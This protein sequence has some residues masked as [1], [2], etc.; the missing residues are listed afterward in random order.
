MSTTEEYITCPECEGEGRVWFLDWLYYD[1]SHDEHE[2]ECPI[3][4][5]SGEV[6]SDE[7][8][9]EEDID[10]RWEEHEERER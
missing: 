9:E 2:E 5:G 1:G 10:L 7:E 8:Y 4:N 6:L 3:C